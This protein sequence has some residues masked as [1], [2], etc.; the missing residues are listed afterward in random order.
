MESRI[1]PQEKEL[2]EVHYGTPTDQPIEFP[3]LDDYDDSDTEL[4]ITPEDVILLL[5]FDPLQEFDETS[6]SN[7]K[8]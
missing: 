6:T 7:S 3:E 2:P 1:M 4:E 5:G 8:V